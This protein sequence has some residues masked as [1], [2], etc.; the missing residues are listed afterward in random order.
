MQ[1]GP[2][3]LIAGHGEFSIGTQ[4]LAEDLFDSFIIIFFYRCPSSLKARNNC[5]SKGCSRVLTSNSTVS[6]K[7]CCGWMSGQ[8][9]KRASNSCVASSEPSANDSGTAKECSSAKM[10][11]ADEA[12]DDG[13]GCESCSIRVALFVIVFDSFALTE[14]S[15]AP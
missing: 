5:C 10:S 13:E 1:Q 2:I 9:S 4:S 6:L 8:R 15:V 14:L 3:A 7:A 12:F 11:E